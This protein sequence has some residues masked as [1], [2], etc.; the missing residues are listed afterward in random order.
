V[1]Y[2]LGVDKSEGEDDLQEPVE[3]EFFGEQLLLLAHLL[4]VVGQVSLCINP[5][6]PSQYSITMMK[7]PSSIKLSIYSTMFGCFS[8]SS[9]FA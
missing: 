2:F 9:S 3:D 7:K 8:C 5:R 6:I 4:D 1:E